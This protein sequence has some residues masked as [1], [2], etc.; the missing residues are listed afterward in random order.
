M[1]DFH[2]NGYVATLHNLRTRSDEE[3]ERELDAIAQTQRITLILPSLY[4]ELQTDA[5]PLI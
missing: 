3:L 1:A 2:Q 5:L 4:S